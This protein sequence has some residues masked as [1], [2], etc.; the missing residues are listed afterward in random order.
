MLEREV[1]FAAAKMAAGLSFVWVIFAS[2]YI[3]WRVILTIPISGVIAFIL[4]R[5]QRQ[6]YK[7]LLCGNGLLLVDNF[8]DWNFA[9]RLL[10]C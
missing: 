3:D 5:Y 4:L 10:S 6:T 1:H 2:A 9:L 8:H 7:G